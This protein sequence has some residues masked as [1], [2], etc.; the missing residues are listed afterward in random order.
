MKYLV[1]QVAATVSKM[2]LEMESWEM[3][4]LGLNL[5][6]ERVPTNVRASTQHL[7]G[8]LKLGSPVA[9][10]GTVLRTG[11]ETEVMSASL[12]VPEVLNV[13]V[14]LVLNGEGA[15]SLCQSAQE[16]RRIGIGALS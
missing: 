11:R 9:T 8:Q 1:Y 13:N 4:A 10:A 7:G 12:V 6:V 14:E 16:S 15:P 5:Y 2:K 3:C